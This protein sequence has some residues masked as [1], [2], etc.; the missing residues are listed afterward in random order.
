MKPLHCV[1]LCL[2]VTS[3]AFAT[4]TRYYVIPTGS[5]ASAGTSWA[6]AF[7]TFRHADSVA[8]SGDTVWVAAGTYTPAVSDPNAYFKLK[9]G[10][11]I[12]GG[13]AGTE[14]ALNQRNWQTNVTTLS[15]AGTSHTVVYALV[16]DTTA[17]LDGFVVTGGSSTSDGA[18]I[19]LLVASPSLS[20]LTITGNHTTANG[21]G[22]CNNS[23]NPTITNCSFIQNSAAYGGG[24]YNYA[25]GVPVISRCI[26]RNDTAT[27]FGGGFYNTGNT[28]N[29]QDV[30][31]EGN[32]TTTGGGG[33]YED[34]GSTYVNLTLYG[35]TS[36]YGGA[37]FVTGSSP[38]IINTI[39]WNDTATT[40]ASEIYSSG[41]SGSTTIS[42]SIVQGGVSAPGVAGP[43]SFTDGGHNLD[44]DPL[45]TDSSAHNFTLTASSPA[46]DSGTNTGVTATNDL[47]GN[48][49]ISNGTVDL[50]A[51]EFQ[52]APLAVE[53]ASLSATVAQNGVEL[54]WTT[55]TEVNNF[56]FT[57]ER[58]DISNS[59]ST[60]GNAQWSDV[61]FVQGAGTSASPHHYTF[62]DANVHPGDYSYRIKLRDNNGSFSYTTA[63]EVGVGS[64]PKDFSLSQNYPN[65]FNP[66]TTMRFAIPT[67]GRVV[68]K[69]Y[70]IL[71][72][73]MATLLDGQQ[74]AGTYNVNF[75]ASL[76]SS[77]VYFYRLSVVGNDGRRFVSTKR[78][79]LIK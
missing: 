69:V 38:T 23:G 48:T 74:S 14:T 41:S 24:M 11:V 47:A 76:Y 78:L 6:A 45:F 72:K 58:R 46:I 49:R 42:Y 63:L 8:M 10:V 68:L 22:L 16:A 39:A 9:S 33:L 19:S 32:H 40:T 30:L 65:P 75:N 79:T 2:T 44:L 53:M 5:D 28:L 61:G 67:D 15:G 59:Q 56:G 27:T 73:E 26:F 20:N 37:I 18:G 12:Y 52:R 51:Y 25:G 29:V 55:A 35:N 64:E 21:G 70:D 54:R 50:G 13:F 60:I 43:G 4:G 36:K 31:F 7:Q 77:G 66:S 1:A 62:I 34:H 71:G 17:V 3:L 57:V